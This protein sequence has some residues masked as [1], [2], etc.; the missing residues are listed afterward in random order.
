[1]ARVPC[2]VVSSLMSIFSM[3]CHVQPPANLGLADSF[4]NMVLPSKAV[5]RLIAAGSDA[6]SYP[7]WQILGIVWLNRTFGRFPGELR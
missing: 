5:G 4:F 1:M 2:E 6:A 3:I 7:A